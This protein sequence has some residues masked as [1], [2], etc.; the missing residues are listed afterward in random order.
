MQL[1]CKEDTS[2]F[3]EF[4]KIIA[5]LELE[6]VGVEPAFTGLLPLE[7]RVWPSM[8]S[9]ECQFELRNAISLSINPPTFVH[10]RELCRVVE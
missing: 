5:T 1:N 4:T 3:T 9:V 7:Y 6:F 8:Q 2:L 10:C